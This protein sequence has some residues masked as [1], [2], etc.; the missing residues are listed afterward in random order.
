MKKG[1]FSGLA[2]ALTLAAGFLLL[3]FGANTPAASAEGATGSSV[4]PLYAENFSV[5]GLEGGASLLT[6]GDRESF[7]LLPAGAEIPPDCSGLPQ[8]TIPVE[9]IYLASSSVADLFLQMNALNR[10]RCV[11]TDRESW[12]IPE[13]RRALENGELLY[14]GKYSTP[15]YELLLEENCDLVVENTMILHNPETRE[16]LEALGFP[17]MLEYSS[18]EP[19]PLGRVEWIR[20]YGLL[21]GK[22][23]EAEAFFERQIRLFDTM[24]TEEK[25]GKTVAFF[26]LTSNGAAVVRRRDDYVTRMIE[27][28]GGETAI[29]ELPEQ[30]NA[31]STMT[32]QMESFYAQARDA[33]ILVYNS[34]VSGEIRT[35]EQLLSLSPLLAEFKAVRDGAV[36]CT[37]QSMFQRSSAAAEMIADFHEL[38]KD[39]PNEEA[40]CY[41]HRIS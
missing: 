3:C 28:A 34:T 7:L 20:L 21:T 32:I 18:Y 15:D 8:I 13:I 22:T 38:M 5:T 14:I 27:Y 41:F 16:K 4:M 24:Q 10:V 35:R 17:V 40:L 12:Q 36:W 33:D 9:R 19:H 11:S 1:P 29:T 30:E 25:S 6:L 2:L 37:E 39:E 31:L 26:H 23:E